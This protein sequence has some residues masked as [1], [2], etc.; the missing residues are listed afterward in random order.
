[1]R[2]KSVAG[3]VATAQPPGIGIGIIRGIGASDS[4]AF[5]TMTVMLSNATPLSNSPIIM[6]VVI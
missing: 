3:G 6:G 1:M 5:C 2:F 4:V